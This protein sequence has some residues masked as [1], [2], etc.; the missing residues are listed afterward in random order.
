VLNSKLANGNFEEYVRKLEKSDHSSWE[1]QEI[2][3]FG[4]FHKYQ[5][6]TYIQ[7]AVKKILKDEFI[8]KDLGKEKITPRAL[9]AKLGSLLLPP[10][11]FG[12]APSITKPTNK[13][14]GKNT[15]TTKLQKISNDFTFSNGELILENRLK[16]SKDTF[17]VCFEPYIS[18]DSSSSINVDEWIE[19]GNS[20]PIKLKDISIVVHKEN[21][22]AISSSQ[23]FSFNLEIIDNKIEK[24]SPIDVEFLKTATNEHY[25][26]K[27]IKNSI[28][29]IE[30]T[31]RH[32]YKI[33]DNSV[34][35]DFANYV[36]AGTENE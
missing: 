25:G 14:S 13:G 20:S 15:Q 31:V 28:F 21:N 36:E 10:E 35:L 23:T 33:I 4:D 6:V 17:R 7:R 27:L 1:E 26:F 16:L 12:N 34:L 3:Q 2:P 11:G 22:K 19:F 8:I 29:P 30:F 9:Q 24:N 32:C 5:P 18:T